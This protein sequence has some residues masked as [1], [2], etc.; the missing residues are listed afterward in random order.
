MI[1]NFTEIEQSTCKVMDF[2]DLKDYR[3]KRDDIIND[4]EDFNQED[5]DEN[6]GV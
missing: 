2:L 6:S 5:L 1:S 4:Y 3:P